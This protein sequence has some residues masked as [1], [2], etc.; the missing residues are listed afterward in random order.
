MINFIKTYIVSLIVIG[1]IDIPVISQ[2]MS[3]MWKKMI[4]DI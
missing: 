4:E 2:I 3:P 1:I